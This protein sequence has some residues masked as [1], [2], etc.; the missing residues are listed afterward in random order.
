MMAQTS[1]TQRKMWNEAGWIIIGQG[2]IVVYLLF[3]IGNF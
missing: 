3:G 1:I 2:Y